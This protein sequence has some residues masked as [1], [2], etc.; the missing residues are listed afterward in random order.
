MKS[1][2]FR[3]AQDE[4]ANEE[5]L[6][7]SSGNQEYSSKETLLKR[8][9]N[10]LPPLH[11]P[12]HSSK[13]SSRKFS[14][15]NMELKTP[16]TSN[17]RTPQHKILQT[18]QTRCQVMHATS[19][20]AEDPFY[21]HQFIDP[22][23]TR[24]SFLPMNDEEIDVFSSNEDNISDDESSAGYRRWFAKIYNCCLFCCPLKK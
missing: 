6:N 19:A 22:F 5:S 18:P 14:F 12:S 10:K 7:E 11:I 4:G 20:F 15:D 16:L 13:R 21:G 3:N 2:P 23:H 24:V 1:T 9:S 8:L 17:M